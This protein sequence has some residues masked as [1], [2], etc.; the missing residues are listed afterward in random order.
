LPKT[1]K[2][3]EKFKDLIRTG[4]LKNEDDIVKVEENFE[5]ALKNVN[6]SIAVSQVKNLNGRLNF[7]K[8][9]SN[10]PLF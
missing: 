6:N 7:V 9:N 4:V 5:E 1:Y 8:L 10:F 3:K 2:E